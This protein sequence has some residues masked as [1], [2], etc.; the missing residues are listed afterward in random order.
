MRVHVLGS[1][2]GGGSP[3]WNCA[4]PMCEAVRRGD[5]GPPRTQES[6]AVD[7]A[8]GWLL[9]NASPEIR[10]QIESFEALRPEPPRRTPILGVVLTNADL[11]HCLG[12][13]SLREG[14]P[15]DVFA[16]DAVRRSFEENNVL[17]RVLDRITWRPLRFGSSGGVEVGGL[18]LE[19]FPVPGK[20]PR[21]LEGL[22]AGADEDNV[23]LRI[24]DA[25]GRTLV[26]ASSVGEMTRSLVDALSGAD[27]VFFDGTFA[28]TDELAR[29]ASSPRS[30]KDMA[31]LPVLGP[32]GSLEKLARLRVGR[33]IFIHVNNTNPMLL[34]RSAE[35]ATVEAAGWEVAW[36]GMDFDV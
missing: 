9:L 20:P 10:R 35:R 28:G 22:R 2:A 8:S 21:Y 27:C 34:D 24:R 16:T 11:D 14:T 4:C 12:L 31:H 19:A 17:C 33:R 7:A 18:S 3:Q 25:R 29:H 23:G 6:V 1:A 36:D 26:Y 32:G 15:L 30:A 5:G 13:L